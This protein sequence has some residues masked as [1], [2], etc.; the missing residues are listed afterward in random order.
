MSR[1]KKTF[2]N[3]IQ[4]K[5]TPAR[6]RRPVAAQFDGSPVLFGSTVSFG[7][8][9]SFGGVEK[10]EALDGVIID[11]LSTQASGSR[12]IHERSPR[13]VLDAKAVPKFENY[14]AKTPKPFSVNWVAPMQIKGSGETTDDVILDERGIFQSF[15]SAK[16]SFKNLTS[17]TIHLVAN[18]G[19]AEPNSAATPDPIASAEIATRVFGL[20]GFRETRKIPPKGMIT[21]KLSPSMIGN[22]VVPSTISGTGQNTG[23]YFNLCTFLP[24]IPDVSSQFGA[25]MPPDTEVMSVVIRVKSIV[26]R[27]TQFGDKR[28]QLRREQVF[29]LGNLE[30]FSDL[31][32][33]VSLPQNATYSVNPGVQVTDGK[34][35]IGAPDGVYKIEPAIAAAG[36]VLSYAKVENGHGYLIEGEGRKVRVSARISTGVLFIPL[37][38]AGPRSFWSFVNHAVSFID[39]VVPIATQ[40]A[41]LFV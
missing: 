7:T 10:I 26:N 37:H 12:L 33:V 22:K 28:S 6:D 2:P 15:K 27:N 36:I 41:G 31:T 20:P 3:H 16:I 21:Y 4:K 39:K 17:D 35:D 18:T 24:Y 23:R 1:A 19:L 29:A 25:E 14:A 34:F 13:M 38:V 5:V 30:Q 9:C 40:V 11:P 32:D 8:R